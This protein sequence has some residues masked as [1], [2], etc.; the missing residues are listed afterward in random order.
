[1]FVKKIYQET[2][3]VPG[4]LAKK[5]TEWLS[6]QENFINQLLVRGIWTQSWSDHDEESD[7]VWQIYT[8]NLVRF[9]I[10]NKTNHGKI[11][12]LLHHWSAY[13]S[14]KFQDY[15]NT[16]SDQRF[17]RQKKLKAMERL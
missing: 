14:L 11:K 2:E 12:I 16:E 5:R 9:M 1:V 4:I 15:S 10:V 8:Q 3:N 6:F 17:Q 7:L 13:R